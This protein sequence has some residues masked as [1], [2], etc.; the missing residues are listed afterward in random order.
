MSTKKKQEPKAAPATTIALD[1]NP[2]PKIKGV[3]GSKYDV[4]NYWLINSTLSAL[5]AHS[6]E[7]S[8]QANA[9][10]SLMADMRA[11]DPIEGIL[12]S[13]LIAASQGSMRMY[14]L[15]WA[16]PS[17][18]FEARIRYLAL[19]DKAARTAA[20]LTER[21]DH[22]RGRSQQKIVVQHTTTVNADQAVVTTGGAAPVGSAVASPAV[23]A[24]TTQMPMQTLDG[25]IEPEPVGVGGGKKKE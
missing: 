20:L 15:A 2:K 4:W 11:D 16:Q 21:L 23:L 25:V 5:P 3:G 13:Q 9:V 1:P 8:N 22:H 14:R 12:I 18:C 19:A 6:D 7:K 17:E 10:V 24:A